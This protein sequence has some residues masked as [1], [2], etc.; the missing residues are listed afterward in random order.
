MYRPRHSQHEAILQTAP[1][2][3]VVIQLDPEPDDKRK[4]R[5]ALL[6]LLTKHAADRVTEYHARLWR[7]ADRERGSMGAQLAG[8]IIR[9]D[10]EPGEKRK[11]LDALLAAG[12]VGSVAEHLAAMSRP[13]VQ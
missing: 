3:A 11:I 7:L 4:A 2:V 5:D 6:T 13:R 8:L 1:L 10:P 12:V 9:L